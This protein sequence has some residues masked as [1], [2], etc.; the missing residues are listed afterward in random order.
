[1]IALDQ[2]P[3]AT[4]ADARAVLLALSPSGALVTVAANAELDR[5]Q[6][7]VDRALADAA[8]YLAPSLVARL[9]TDFARAVP[10]IAP[11]VGDL[12]TYV[13][14]LLAAL[15]GPAAPLVSFGLK[16]ACA[17]AMAALVRWAAKRVA[18]A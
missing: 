16:I 15:A 9:E 2:A 13:I 12:E 11:A 7:A 5:L 14:P 10:V 1:V 6:D 8:A 4:D 18:G 17:V 3:T